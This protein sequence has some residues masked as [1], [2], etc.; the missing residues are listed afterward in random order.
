[1]EDASCVPS[2]EF[3]GVDDG[4]DALADAELEAASD[5]T[6]GDTEVVSEVEGDRDPD[7]CREPVLDALA[8]GDALAA[9]EKLSAAS[10]V[11]DARCVPSI[12]SPG[13]GDGGADA[14]GDTELDGAS[15]LD[16]AG[17]YE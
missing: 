8:H 2:I 13:V 6:R 15:E 9:A 4:T 3:T 16:A 12:D 17:V 7:D 1:M 14:E 10:A 11:A 5:V